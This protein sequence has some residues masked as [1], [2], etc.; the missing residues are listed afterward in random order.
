MN[1][2]EVI[3][4]YEMTP[5]EAKAYKLCVLW[6]TLV[7]KEFPNEWATKLRKKGD[8][9]KST[10]FKYCYKLARETKGLIPDKEYKLYILDQLHVLRLQNDGKVH[11]LIDPFILVGDK[12]WKR[13]KLWRK[14]YMQQLEKPRTEEELE[15]QE[16]KSRVLINLDR[17]KKFLE[18][19]G[20]TSLEQIKAKLDDLSLIR[21]V[22][23][24]KVSPH[25]AILSPW[26]SAAL[27]GKTL[28]EV[29]LFDLTVYHQSID[30]D[31]EKWFSE[32]F[33][34]EF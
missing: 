6:D 26:I 15:I 17:T 9:R 33:A 12:A 24:G 21:W 27:D 1:P 10:L 20:V 25:Y 5:D 3:L 31:V 22:S 4:E 30:K 8:P 29:F 2:L 32:N 13:W 23:L 19:E 7:R 18:K 11:A 14:Y 34:E 16:K 28:E